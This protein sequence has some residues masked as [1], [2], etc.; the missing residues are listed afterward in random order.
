MRTKIIILTP[1][2]SRSK[3]SNQEALLKQ[4]HPCQIGKNTY[5]Q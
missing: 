1:R 4:N 5:S 3:K 2:K